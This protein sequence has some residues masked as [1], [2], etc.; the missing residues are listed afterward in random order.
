MCISC[1][2]RVCCAYRLSHLRDLA[3]VI[4]W[5]MSWSAIDVYVFNCVANCVKYSVRNATELISI[6]IL[7]ML[8]PYVN[9]NVVHLP[10][11]GQ[12]LMLSIYLSFMHMSFP[13]HCV[14]DPRCWQCTPTASQCRVSGMQVS[15]EQ[16][17]VH[18]QGNDPC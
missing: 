2:S 6:A 1:L 13:K 14:K 16:L 9:R 3:I 8:R 11:R 4:V 17:I 15:T 10:T 18:L 5:Y 7:C 12:P